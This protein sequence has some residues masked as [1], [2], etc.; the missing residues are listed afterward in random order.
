MK[1]LFL[2]LVCL[3]SIPLWGGC[4]DD[5]TEYYSILP[6]FYDITFDTDQ[7]YSHMTVTATAVQSKKGNLLDRTTYDWYVNDTITKHD[8]LV[9]D[10]NNGDPVFTFKVPAVATSRPASINVT[11]TGKYRVSGKGNLVS[12]RD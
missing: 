12:L 9:Y 7:L 3:L 11:F 1:K 6:T 10:N 5:D 2:T 4:G 8:G